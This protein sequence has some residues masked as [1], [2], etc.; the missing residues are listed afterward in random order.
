VPVSD[1]RSLWGLLS[2]GVSPSAVSLAGGPVSC[3]LSLAVTSAISTTDIDRFEGPSRTRTRW[4]GSL[5]GSLGRRI[6]ARCP[7]WI[8]TRRDVVEM[9]SAGQLLPRRRFAAPPQNR[10][11]LRVRVA[12]FW[13]AL[14]GW[15]TG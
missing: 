3:R 6:V 8:W 12:L 2:P 15:T 5:V 10:S 9:S 4:P 13:S 14:R 7:R 11:P 1:R